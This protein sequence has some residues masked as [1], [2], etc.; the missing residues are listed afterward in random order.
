M[1]TIYCMA[2]H[3]WVLEMTEKTMTK[4]PGDDVKKSTS[5]YSWASLLYATKK[6]V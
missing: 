2:K 4:V 5:Y 6:H 1:H 3:Q